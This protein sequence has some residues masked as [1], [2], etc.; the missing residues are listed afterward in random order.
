MA[1]IVLGVGTSHT[2]QISV[3][4]AEWPTL[5]RTQEAS[6]H[7]PEDLDGQLRPEVFRRRHAA[8]QA[9]VNQL[10]QVLRNADLD[11][12]VIFG[13]DQHEQ[14]D[15]SNM[16]AIAIYHGEQF[17]LKRRDH[18]E[19][20]PGWM[21]VEE[22]NWEQTQPD[23]P[24]SADLA[25]HLIASLTEREFEITRCSQLRENVGIGH[26]FSFLYRRLWP[27]CQVP[28]VP[29][30]LNTYFPPNQPTPKRCYAL[31]EAIRESVASWKGGKRVALMASGGLSHIVIDEPLDQQLLDALRANDQQ[32][33]FGFPRALLKGGTSEALNWIAVAGGAHHLKMTLIDYI[34]GY[35]TPPST[36]CAMAFA[37]WN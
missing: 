26:A 6:P 19:R 1:D 24:N 2:P 28:I 29:V 32:A 17:S 9:A 5:G 18:G 34:P 8:A 22:A 37:Y 30:M 33:L 36:G 15:D 31:G 3:P 25:K 10:G 13:D 12:I 23:Y 7:I 4:W 27:D 16:P 11:A 21:K 14:F 35:R 20:T